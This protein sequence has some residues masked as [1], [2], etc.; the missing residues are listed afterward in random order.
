MSQAIK[1]N[2]EYRQVETERLGAQLTI[3]APEL[4]EATV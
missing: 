1:L 3:T 4:L 2:I